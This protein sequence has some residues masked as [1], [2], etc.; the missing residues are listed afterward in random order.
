MISQKEKEPTE[1]IH[2]HM[3]LQIARQ[4]LVT[5]YILG[6]ILLI[7]SIASPD[8]FRYFSP[9]LIYQC[10]FSRFRMRLVPVRSNCCLCRSTSK[11]TLA[12][13]RLCH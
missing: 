4:S 2:Y 13:F 5:Q 1:Y 12:L 3:M 8:L 9:T 10:V 11:V 6:D 7:D